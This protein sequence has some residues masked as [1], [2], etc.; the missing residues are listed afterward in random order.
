MEDDACGQGA[1]ETSATLF[2]LFLKCEIYSRIKG[3]SGVS[4]LS[5][6]DLEQKTKGIGDEKS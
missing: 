3:Y 1:V 2:A 5:I 6:F 4:K